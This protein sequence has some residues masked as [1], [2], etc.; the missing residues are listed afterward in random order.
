MS[1]LRR[2]AA[3]GID[4]VLD[5]RFAG[6]RV[7]NLGQVRMHAFALTGGEDDDIHGSRL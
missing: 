6:Q 3:R 1:G 5:Q 2:Q 7:E 4:D